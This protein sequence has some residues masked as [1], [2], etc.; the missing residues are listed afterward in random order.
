LKDENS[1]QIGFRGWKKIGGFNRR[2][3]RFGRVPKR[4]NDRWSKRRYRN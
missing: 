1:K 4:G 3:S 2:P